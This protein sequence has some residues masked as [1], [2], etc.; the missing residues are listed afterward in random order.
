MHSP[1]HNQCVNKALR[2][3]VW[4]HCIIVYIQIT[5]CTI[6]TKRTCNEAEAKFVG[7]ANAD[8]HLLKPRVYLWKL[9]FNNFVQLWNS[10][11]VQS[12]S[13]PVQSIYNREHPRIINTA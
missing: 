5:H 10:E 4:I 11:C 1:R 13:N 12:Q 8:V 7:F 2:C 3:I 6:I 9:P